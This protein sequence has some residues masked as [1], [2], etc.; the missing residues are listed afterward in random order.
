MV[1]VWIAVVRVED[2]RPVGAGGGGGIMAR[3]SLGLEGRDVTFGFEREDDEP[4]ERMTLGLVNLA[5]GRFWRS[6]AETSPKNA[7]SQKLCSIT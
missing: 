2:C 6:R 4:V 3:L 7:S 1:G 5:Q